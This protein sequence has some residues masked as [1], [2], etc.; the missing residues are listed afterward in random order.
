MRFKKGDTVVRSGASWRSVVQYNA[1]TV[2]SHVHDVL[3]LEEL[4]G[5]Y[6]P[7]HFYLKDRKE[8]QQNVVGPVAAQGT[9]MKFDGDKLRMDLLIMG[10]PEALE[11]VADVLT[12]GARKYAADSWQHVPDGLRRYEGAAM[13]HKS[14]R[15][16]GEWLDPES[17]KPHIYHEL[18]CMLF[19]AQLHEI[20]NKEKSNVQ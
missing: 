9:G 3:E 5:S 12:F 19:I 14:A 11:G 20:T 16:K 18:C 6:D 13:R 4:S 10:M 17:G 15:L 7:D 8:T 2:K 1:Y